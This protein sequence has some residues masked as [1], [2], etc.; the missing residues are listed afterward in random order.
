ML[1]FAG[2]SRQSPREAVRAQRFRVRC[3]P[4]EV[5]DLRKRDD[6][7]RRRDQPQPLPTIEIHRY[8]ASDAIEPLASDRIIRGVIGILDRKEIA[9]R[10]PKG[11]RK[12]YQMQRRAIP[13]ATLDA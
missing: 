11:T 6:K 9:D 8:I 3:R 12:L 13:N 2:R 5:R 4:I 7:N 1:S 10:D